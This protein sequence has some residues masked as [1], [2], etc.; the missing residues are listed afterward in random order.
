[1]PFRGVYVPL[2]PVH[3]ATYQRW[4]DDAVLEAARV[5][6]WSRGAIPSG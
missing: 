1:V 3:F 4:G 2:C 6:D 5:W